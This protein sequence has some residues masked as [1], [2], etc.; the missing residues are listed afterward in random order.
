MKKKSKGTVLT[1]RAR[2]DIIRKKGGVKGMTKETKRFTLRLTGELKE[3]LDE[4]RKR[5]GVSLNALVV[6]ILWDWAERQ[7]KPDTEGNFEEGQR[8]F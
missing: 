1:P 4:S 7:G 3:R 2:H 6:Q 5:K 8:E